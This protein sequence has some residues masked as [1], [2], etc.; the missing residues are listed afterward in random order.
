MCRLWHAGTE[1]AASMLAGWLAGWL[2]CCRIAMIT[3]TEAPGHMAAIHYW[4][5]LG[6]HAWS[7]MTG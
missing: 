5:R 6:H 7:F 4:G 1:S 2:G 3:R